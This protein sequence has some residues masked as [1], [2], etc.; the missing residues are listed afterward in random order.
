MGLLMD[1][2]TAMAELL[3]L[4][5]ANVL[6][7]EVIGALARIFEHPVKLFCAEP[8]VRAADGVWTMS[9]TSRLQASNLLVKLVLAVRAFDWE[10]V[11]VAAKQHSNT[12]EPA[13]T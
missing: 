13:S 3:G 5:K 7:P 6:P 11:I 10:V 12:P 8:D 4:A 2:E 9:A 1:Y